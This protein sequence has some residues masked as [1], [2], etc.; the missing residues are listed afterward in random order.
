MSALNTPLERAVA[1]FG[2]V[3][4]LCRATGITSK[5]VYRWRQAAAKGGRDG[6]VPDD[7]QPVI[8]R[9]AREL[10]I[11]LTAEDLI[12]MRSAEPAPETEAAP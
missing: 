6:R 5:R 7:A 12:D 1:V 2:S 4:A 3:D 8:L 9:A 10:G 11:P